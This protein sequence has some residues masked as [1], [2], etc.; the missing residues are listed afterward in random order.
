ML[1]KHYG[2]LIVTQRKPHGEPEYYK[3]EVADAIEAMHLCD[4]LRKAKALAHWWL[5]FK[6][7]RYVR[8]VI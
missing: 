1:H 5:E 7:K 6:S 2:T 3:R 8:R 4:A